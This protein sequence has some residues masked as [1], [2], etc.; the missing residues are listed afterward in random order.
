MPP[1]THDC[2]AARRVAGEASEP[3]H[4]KAIEIHPKSATAYLLLTRIYMA[5]KNSQQ[6]IAELTALADKTNSSGAVMQ[7]AVIHTQLKDYEAARKDYER[8]LTIDPKFMPALNNLAV[9]YRS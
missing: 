1:S 2:F 6:A 7:L 4:R 9:L 3:G 5:T 8:L